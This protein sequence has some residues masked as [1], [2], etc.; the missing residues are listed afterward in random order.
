MASAAFVLACRNLRVTAPLLRAELRVPLPLRTVTGKSQIWSWTNR[1]SIRDLG[2][3]LRRWGA[4]SEGFGRS[5]KD[6]D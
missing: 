2:G 1:E 5:L 6:E 4:W 3:S